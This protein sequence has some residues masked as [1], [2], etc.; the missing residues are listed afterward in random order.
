MPKNFPLY[1]RT[2][3]PQNETDLQFQYLV[4]TCIDVVEEKGQWYIVLVMSV[5]SFLDPSQRRRVWE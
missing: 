4:H 1:L 2:V 5:I 3:D